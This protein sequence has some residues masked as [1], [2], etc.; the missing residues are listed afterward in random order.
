[1]GMAETNCPWT[2]RTQS[3]FN[4]MMN[5]RFCSSH[6]RERERITEILKYM[7]WVREDDDYRSLLT[8]HS[9]RQSG[10]ATLT[11]GLGWGLE[12]SRN[13]SES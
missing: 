9:K 7:L 13:R 8:L 4:M 2:P 1:M 11:P 3:E 10:G 6:T 12:C 5:Q